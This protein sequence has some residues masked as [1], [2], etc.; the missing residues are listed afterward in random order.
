MK[1]MWNGKII[2]IRRKR[3]KKEE[4]LVGKSLLVIHSG[5]AIAGE[6]IADQKE[7]EYKKAIEFL[8]GEKNEEN[9]N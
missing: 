1:I 2:W 3:K 7:S 5:E 6:I 4:N 8:E 9:K